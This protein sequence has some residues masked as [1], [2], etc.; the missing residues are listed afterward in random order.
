[1]RVK[2]NARGVPA[3]STTHLK[4]Y[5]LQLGGQSSRSVTSRNLK[6]KQ[7]GWN[8]VSPQI[9]TDYDNEDEMDLDPAGDHQLIYNDGQTKQF[10]R[11]RGRLPSSIAPRII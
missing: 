7:R 8:T 11:E 6:G 4:K 1:M 9:M 2:A 3:I 5:L 10:I